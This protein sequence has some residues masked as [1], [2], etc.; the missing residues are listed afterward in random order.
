MTSHEI[1][2]RVSE[3][4]DG[5]KYRLL[6][7]HHRP[8]TF[9]QKFQ[10]GCNRRFKPSY[11]E[12][13][14][15][16]AY[17]SHLDAAFCIPCVLYAKEP[18]RHNLQALVNTPFNRWSRA[19]ILQDHKGKKYHIQSVVL[20]KEFV[21]TIH[22]PKKK[23]TNQ[24]DSVRLQN[25]ANN[26]E[27]LRHI[28][29]AIVYL[30]QQG[31]ALRGHDETSD[32]KNRGNFLELLHL[33]AMYSPEFN[34]YLNQQKKTSYTS[35]ASQNEL[36]SVIGQD[37]IRSQIVKDVQQARFFAVICDEAS[38]GKQEYLSMIIRFLDSSNT[39]REEFIGF[40]P[41]LKCTGQVLAEQIVEKLSSL[42]IDIE[43][44][45]GQGYDGA[46]A[47]SSDRCGVQAVIKEKAPSAAYVHCASHCLNLVIGHSC[48]VTSVATVMQKITMVREIES[49]NYH[50]RFIMNLV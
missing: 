40:H 8:K 47:M 21:S 13:N 4:S 42:G 10:D 3:M 18:M 38:S 2:Q 25:I 29:N 7:N 37:C 32:S 41:V 46:A 44:C 14:S 6:T 24:I 43:R 36:I 23:I 19:K 49:I 27:M 15:W 5:E 34:D 22:N 33:L 1:A 28:I 9:P 31:M 48:R 16:L 45:R 26:R 11:F 12:G 30:T 35:P 39:I 17:S 20:S 50:Y